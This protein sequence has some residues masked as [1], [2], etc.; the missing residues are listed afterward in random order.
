MRDGGEPLAATDIEAGDVLVFAATESGVSA[1]WGS[2]R[3]GLRTASALRGL[4]AQPAAR[5]PRELED[6]AAC[7]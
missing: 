6:D 5:D 2:P 3:F 7:T 1:L 4:G